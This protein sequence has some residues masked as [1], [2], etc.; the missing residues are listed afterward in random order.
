MARP[1]RWSSL[2]GGTLVLCAFALVLVAI[3][4]YARVGQLH[5]AK[6]TVFAAT[7]AARGVMPRVTDVWYEGQKIGSVEDIQF[8]PIDTDTGGRIVMRLQVLRSDLPFLRRDVDAQIRSGGSLIGSPVVFFS[9]GTGRAPALREGDT[10]R[11]Q[12][13]GDVEGMTS[14]IALASRDFP[15]IIGDAKAIGAALGTVRGTAG[16][17]LNDQRGQRELQLLS[18]NTSGLMRRVSNGRGSV[19]LAMRGDLGGRA[20]RAMA[21]ADS[22][23]TLLSSGE[24]S[25]GRFRRD[26]TIL[27]EMSDVR[28]E[29]SIVQALLAEPRGTAGRVLADSAAYQELGSMQRQIGALIADVKRD[30]LRYLAF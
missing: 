11:M 10:I 29:L 7:S 4:K 26:S 12:T 15:A 22:I 24:T 28:S 17:V 21:R 9:G 14:Q 16:A 2:V 19:A 25:L 8:R 6:V 5:G 30:P 3:V 13:Q 23:R 27:R 18:A 1:L 20:S